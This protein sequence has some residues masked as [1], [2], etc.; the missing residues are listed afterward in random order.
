MR[1]I[2]TQVG[3]VGAGP[4][5][6]LLGQLLH[7]NGIDSVIIENRS[8]E[9]VID[10]VRADVLEQ[11]TVDLF[12]AL[13]DGDRLQRLGLPSCDEL[14]Y[15]YHERGICALQHALADD[16]ASVLQVP[17]DESIENWTDEAIWEEMLQR[18]TT[19]DGWR[20]PA[21]GLEGAAIL[22]VDDVDT[23]P[24]SGGPPVRLPKADCRSR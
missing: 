10:R 11:G 21:A 1:A 6:L 15:T 20:V 8:R 18:M 4:A 3:I 5:G 16:H 23:A 14:D 12:S 13:G 17:P 7:L 22:L 19:R 9:Y 24:L 2:R